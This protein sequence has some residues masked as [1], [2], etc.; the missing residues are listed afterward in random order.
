MPLRLGGTFVFFLLSRHMASSQ[1][2]STGVLGSGTMMVSEAKKGELI[3]PAKPIAVRARWK[4]LRRMWP[5][6]N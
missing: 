5:G 3:G 1:T 4:K 2:L 6:N